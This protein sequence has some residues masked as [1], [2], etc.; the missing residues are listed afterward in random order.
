MTGEENKDVIVFRS[1][2]IITFEHSLNMFVC[3]NILRNCVDISLI[4]QERKEVSEMSLT[5]LAS[6]I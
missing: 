4:L 6:F 3:F 1:S 5:K 2:N